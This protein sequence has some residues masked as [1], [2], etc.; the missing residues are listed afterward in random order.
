MPGRR[1]FLRR[2]HVAAGASGVNRGPSCRDTSFVALRSGSR[3]LEWL[4]CRAASGAR[5]AG[6]PARRVGL[7]TPNWG[8]VL[9]AQV[10]GRD[11]AG[12]SL[13]S[14]Q[15]PSSLSVV[16]L[17]ISADERST[18][19]DLFCGIDRLQ[20]TCRR[21]SKNPSTV[22]AKTPKIGLEI[23]SVRSGASSGSGEFWRS[24]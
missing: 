4:C 23:T 9:A 12:T 8:P 11:S 21:R 18:D 5:A 24:W 16:R 20:I 6:G 14:L 22:T 3:V 7:P 15:F 10:S 13:L 17:R 19:P 2:R 1:P